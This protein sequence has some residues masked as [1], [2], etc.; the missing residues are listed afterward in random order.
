MKSSVAGKS[1]SAAEVSNV[2]AYGIW[3]LACGREYFLP[4]AGFPW[5]KDATISALLDVRL[6]H[7]RHLYWPR[8]DVDLDVGSLEH[9][10]NYPLTYR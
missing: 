2:T 1:T 5:F 7:S 6:L 3:L 4:Y 9:L 10:E 8:L